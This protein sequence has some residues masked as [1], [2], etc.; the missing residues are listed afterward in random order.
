VKRLIFP[1]LLPGLLWADELKSTLTFADRTVLTGSPKSADGKQKA[2]NF[3]SPS[4]D[5]EATLKTG[6]L[7]EMTLNGKP[8][9]K[10]SDHYALATINDRFDE[11]PPKDTI[12][13]RLLSLD[14]KSVVLDTDYAGKLTLDRL[15]VTSLDIYSKPPSFFNGPDG[16]DGWVCSSGD[17]EDHWTFGNR[18]M[19]SKEQYGIARKVDLPKRSVIKFTAKWKTT[20]YFKILFL[21]NDGDT[22]HP[23]AGYYLNIQSSYMSL[24]R[25]TETGAR[26]DVLNKG[27][28][29]SLRETQEAEFS[30]YLDRDRDGTSAFYINEKLIGT[31]TG[32]DDTKGMG[33]WLHFVPRRTAP[34]QF[35]KIS[36]SQWDGV[37]PFSSDDEKKD[38]ANDEFGEELEGQ[39]IALSNGD[40]VI[41]KIKAVKEAFVHV[42][43]VFG[44]VRIPLN[45][46]RS[47]DLADIKTD[48]EGKTVDLKEQP[49]MWAEDIRAHFHEG[50]SITIRLDKIED[51]KIKGSSQ[52]FGEAEFDLNAFTRLEFNVWSKKLDPARYGNNEKW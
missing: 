10:E 30:I 39:K 44:D 16:P 23:S 31:W 46:M 5:G 41:G 42:E 1:F 6:Q 21:S 36:V 13:G 35:S 7:L 26:D 38:D 33:E 32:T 43:T 25:S 34:L 17:V 20:P 3:I 48:E 27:L 9:V 11:S 29:R 52:V 47:I 2:L 18:S 14:D 49:K 12:R 15:M 4:L 50:G 37:L 40:V 51:G 8:I 24:Y 45:R 19:T 28:D 22:N